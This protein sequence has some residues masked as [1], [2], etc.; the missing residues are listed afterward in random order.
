MKLS[1][2]K[3][4]GIA[5]S[6]IVST[7]F[8]TIIGC[9]DSSPQGGAKLS[10]QIA[11]WSGNTATLDAV[12]E[13]SD[14]K[15][16]ATGTLNT[17]GEFDLVLPASLA[18]E[19]LTAIPSCD[20]VAVTP[21][22]TGFAF[23]SYLEARSGSL[24]WGRVYYASTFI[25][26]SAPG[27][28]GGVWV[29]VD[30]DVSASGT[31]ADVFGGQ[32][33]FA[34]AVTLE[35]SLTKGWNKLSVELEAFTERTLKLSITTAETPAEV[36]WLLDDSYGSGLP[37]AG[38]FQGLGDLPGSGTG[39]VAL[40][41]S[42]DGSVAV[43]W[44]Y[45][46]EGT[47][48]F[49]WDEANDMTS[50]GSI[51]WATSASADGSVI[52]GRGR[53]KDDVNAFRWDAANGVVDLGSLPVGFPDEYSVANDVSA[54]GSVVVG[55]YGP[56]AF[57]WDAVNGMVSL[58]DS[59]DVNCGANAVS[60]DG[61]VIVGHCDFPIEAVRWDGV[62]GPVGLGYLP[63]DDFFSVAEGISADGTV[64]VGRSSG[65]P[66]R[67]D[68]VNGMVGLGSLPGGGVGGTA[69][70]ASRDGSV[71]VGAGV[72]GGRETA[73]IWDAEHGMRAL[74][75]LLEQDHG[76]DLGKWHLASATGIAD[77]GTIIVGYGVLKS[78]P[79]EGQRAWRAVL[80]SRPS[81]LGT[82]R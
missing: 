51:G 75:T 56:K 33:P 45:S 3:S 23:V 82:H 32:Q 59:G 36:R 34:A 63:G 61:S 39:A 16:I 49:R 57:R 29:Y 5:L 38:N 64:V 11:D 58:K 12:I 54:D 77:D 40:G 31:C 81:S 35:A 19:D 72:L 68:A 60:A 70:D 26:E 13:A 78:D 73:F 8:F 48:A 9:G 27:I 37:V 18:A 14:I 1:H 71:I 17:K 46:E 67:W 30:K 42:A 50:L 22:D 80:G 76:L 43:G 2:L 47:A 41:V 53:V 24:F 66:F 15:S 10:G 20:G 28:T 25:R 52:V 65:E 7:V 6:I 4:L 55:E 44:S 74:Q 21:S 62:D 69:F 79:Q